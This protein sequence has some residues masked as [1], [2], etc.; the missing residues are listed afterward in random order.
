MVIYHLCFS[1]SIA[2]AHSAEVFVSSFSLHHKM[3]LPGENL[4]SEISSFL[5][6]NPTMSSKV[7]ESTTWKLPEEHTNNKVNKRHQ[8]IIKIMEGRKKTQRIEWEKK[9]SLLY[10]LQAGCGGRF[11]TGFRR[12]WF[13]WGRIR[14]IWMGAPDFEPVRPFLTRLLWVLTIFFDLGRLRFISNGHMRFQLIT[15]I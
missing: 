10:F 14:P 11:W 5:W 3:V 1:C 13:R 2:A 15:F 6:W 9:N 8:A 12:I 4:M 7:V